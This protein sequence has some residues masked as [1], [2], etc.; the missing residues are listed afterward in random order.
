MIAVVFQRSLRITLTGLVLLCVASAVGWATPDSA[1]AGLIVGHARSGSTKSVVMIRLMSA[2]PLTL[3]GK[4]LDKD[5]LRVFYARRDYA[6][7]WD[8]G[9]GDPDGAGLAPKAAAVYAVLAAADTEGLEPANYHVGDIARLADASTEA[10]R[11]DRDFLITDGVLRYA[12]DVS[13]GRL[14]PGQ[15]DERPLPAQGLDCALY[16]A[17]AT[18]LAPTELADMLRALPPSTAEYA[19]LRDRLA[20]LRLKM[21][22]GGWAPLPDGPTIHPGARDPAVPFL[23][24]RL[25][26]EERVGPAP[27]RPANADLYDSGL[28]AA[29]AAFQAQHG[30][31]PDGAI[32]KDTRAALDVSLDARVRQ[33]VVN[34]ERARWTDIPITGRMVEVNLA[35][36]SLKVYQDGQPILVMPVVVGT[37][38]NQ[39]PIISSR[40]TTVVLNPNWTLPPNVIKEMLPRIHADQAYLAGKGIG[41]FE[42]DGRV[43]L[44]QPPGPTNPLGH[45]KFVMPNDQDIYLHDSPDAGKFHYTLRAYSHGCVRLGNPAELATLLLDDRVASLPASLADLTQTWETR[46]IPLSKPVPVSLVYRTAWLDK[47]GQLV[48]GEDGYGRDQRLWKALHKARPGQ[49]GKKL[50]DRAV[51][52]HVL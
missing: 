51:Q 12:A 23:R 46:H 37:P 11:I 44:V 2:A 14:S 45:Y 8:R 24:A 38:E 50:A 47:N 5:S 4:A 27:P 28:S 19:A 3:G 22:A 41:R 30:I 31:K 7:A 48:L 35:A 33:V 39:T 52:G 29:V 6:L 1:S 42:S 43:R 34:M 40:I 15:T 21:D 9:E 18:R 49:P 26:A 32:G 10:D 17:S 36:Y 20:E 25:V 13:G 16:M